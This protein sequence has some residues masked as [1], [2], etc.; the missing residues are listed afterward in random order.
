MKKVEILKNMY[1]KMYQIDFF[2]IFKIYHF[3][4]YKI[5]HFLIR[6]QC[7]NRF[8]II[9]FYGTVQTPMFVH[10]SPTDFI[11]LRL[12]VTKI[13]L[14]YTGLEKKRQ[15]CTWWRSLKWFGF[16]YDYNIKISFMTGDRF[17]ANHTCPSFKHIASE[18]TR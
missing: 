9:E 1:A 4:K 3:A 8:Q 11:F 7:L 14:Q 18:V 15:P 17:I 5:I 10:Q 12:W 16:H 13:K 6:F 2:F